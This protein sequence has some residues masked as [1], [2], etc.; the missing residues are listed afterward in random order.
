[1]KILPTIKI[2]D[3]DYRPLQLADSKNFEILMDYCEVN[4]IRFALAGSIGSGAAGF[5]L[6]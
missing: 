2:V 5:A 6:S 4:I 3:T 1:M